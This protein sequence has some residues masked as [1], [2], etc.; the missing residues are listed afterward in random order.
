MDGVSSKVPRSIMRIVAL[1]KRA[2]RIVCRSIKIAH[3]PIRADL[4]S[5]NSAVRL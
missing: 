2:N 3:R 5:G 1:Q 4:Q